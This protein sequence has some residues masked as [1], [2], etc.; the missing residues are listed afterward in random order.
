MTAMADYAITN[1]FP[2]LARTHAL[3]KRLEEGLKG[4]GCEMLAPVDTNMVS[5]A[6]LART[7]QWQQSRQ[8][9]LT[10]LRRCSS[11][12]SHSESPSTPSWHG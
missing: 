4:A 1:H 6:V 10:L 2:R 3:A 8:N 9:E 11:H 7:L 12:R 5:L